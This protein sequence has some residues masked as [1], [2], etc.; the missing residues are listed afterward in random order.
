M[1]AICVFC[2]HI[3]KQKYVFK[4]HRTHTQSA[5]INK[6][7]G[8]VNANGVLLINCLLLN[9]INLFGKSSSCC[10]SRNEDLHDNNNN[11]RRTKRMR[12]ALNILNRKKISA[13]RLQI[14]SIIQMLPNT[15]QHI[16]RRHKDNEL[17][18]CHIANL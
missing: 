13:F 7:F 14:V 2:W 4:T 6:A 10:M 18:H 12:D 11:K 15:T 1:C 8:E 16:W 9:E 3:R 5:K 17:F